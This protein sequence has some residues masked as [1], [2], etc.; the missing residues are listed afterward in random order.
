MRDAQRSL[1]NGPPPLEANALDGVAI[2]IPALDEAKTVPRL[3]RIL[4]VLDPQPA[5]ILLVDGGSAD[6]TAEIARAAGLRVIE[7]HQRAGRH[8]STA[9]CRRSPAHSYAS[10]TPI[11]F[12]RMMPLP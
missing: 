7:H 1:G 2:V 5:E 3:A 9:V 10:F 6:G 4:A 8:R 12:F 11:P